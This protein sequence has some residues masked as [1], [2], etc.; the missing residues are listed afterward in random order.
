MDAQECE[1][2]APRP[3]SAASPP[4]A[5]ASASLRADQIRCTSLHQ[6][7]VLVGVL[8]VN[9]QV[10]VRIGMGESPWS[11]TAIASFGRRGGPLAR[12]A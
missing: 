4:G 5:A 7:P 1:G 6:Q 2:N 11:L 8:A 10:R 3:P 9:Y 12:V